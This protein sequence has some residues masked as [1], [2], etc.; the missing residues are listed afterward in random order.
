MKILS[1]QMILSVLI[2]VLVSCSPNGLAG[3]GSEITNGVC[4]TVS[5]PADSA[6]IIAF[7]HDY[8]FPGK[9]YAMPETT[10]TDKNGYFSI[11]LGDSAWNLLMYDRSQTCGA[12]V[13]LVNGDANIGRVNLDSL[14]YLE[15]TMSDMTFRYGT[16]TIPGSP[17]LSMISGTNTFSI[18]KIP[19]FSYSVLFTKERIGTC[20]P[21]VDCG[22]FF[23]DTMTRSISIQAGKTVN[24]IVP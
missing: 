16:V 9:T 1:R 19:E 13:A 21:G 2:A 18:S 3:N 8:L 22:H 11:V 15:G 10:Y 14:G 4:M 7:P 24:V 12:F 20:A 17:F 5:G 23:L 6:L